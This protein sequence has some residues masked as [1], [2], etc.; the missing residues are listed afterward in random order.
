LITGGDICIYGKKDLPCRIIRDEYIEKLSWVAKQ[1]VVMWDAAEKRGWLVNGACALLHLLLASFDFNRT[2]PLGFAF[3]LN[4]ADIKGPELPFTPGSAMEVLLNPDNL[5]L[6]LYHAKEGNTVET[7]MPP[8]RVRDRVDRLY[9]MLEKIMD[10][11]AEIMGRDSEALRGMPR[12]NLEGWDFKDL[13][14]LEDPLYPRIYK[15]GARGK[16]WVDFTRAIRAAT[17]F[18]TGFGEIIRPAQT[19]QPCPYWSRLPEGKS[20]L[21]ISDDDLANIID[22]FGNPN[23]NPVRLTSHLIWCNHPTKVPRACKCIDDPQKTGHSELAQVILPSHFRKRIPKHNV[24]RR[25]DWGNGAVVFGYNRDF[26]WSWN[27]TGFPEQGG[28]SSSSDDSGSDSNDDF[29]DTGIGTSSVPSALV[30]DG[31]H[32]SPSSKSQHNS[33][34]HEDYEVGIVCALWKELLAVRALFDLSYPD[35]EKDGNDPNCYCLGRMKK[36]NVVAAGLPHDDYGLN[37][38]TNVASHLIRTF[39]RVKFCLVVGIGGGVPSNSKDIR[40]GDIVVGTGVMQFDMGKRFQDSEFRMTGEKQQPPPF[41]RAALTKIQSDFLVSFNSALNPLLDDINQIASLRP[42][43]QFPGVDRDMLF[44]SEYLHTNDESTCDNCTGTRRPRNRPHNGP[45]VFYGLIASGNQVVRDARHRDRLGKK[46]V[47]C[48]EMEAAGVMRTTAD[49]LVIRGICD[50]ADS[51]KNKLWQ[52]YASATAAAYAKFFLSYMPESGG[53]S[54]IRVPSQLEV[55]REQLQLQK[56]KRAA[57]PAEYEV[58][59]LKSCRRH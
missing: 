15:L 48:F 34:T 17:L 4:L 26:Q 43:Y 28:A 55:S 25:K 11:Q 8:V 14:T 16:S 20:Y 36:F 51:H 39:P 21:A 22:R 40:L 31:P 45:N 12:G 59:K 54:S 19:S 56:N 30:D 46:N 38:A 1:Y 50:Y 5:S 10:H 57:S 29:H 53:A 44:D 24:V 35:L 58:L 47:F 49:C 33:L 2:D 37:S 3:R 41:L 23:S 27:D 32:E 7:W 13:A 52:E 9:N 42:E 6:E 18:G